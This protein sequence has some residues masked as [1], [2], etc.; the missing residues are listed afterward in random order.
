MFEVAHR[1]VTVPSWIDIENKATF[2]I[3]DE[4]TFLAKYCWVIFVSGFAYSVLSK[5]WEAI[6][7]IFKDFEPRAV[8]GMKSVELDKFPIKNQRK[9]NSFLEG[10]KAIE[11]E[12]F[13]NFKARLKNSENSIDMLEELE[14][15][16]PITKFHLA[17]SIGLADTAKPDIWLRRCAK[18]CSTNVE[19]LVSFLSDEYNMTKYEVDGILWDYCRTNQ[20]IPNPLPSSI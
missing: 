16:G 3:L 9:I 13:G 11:R 19:N 4:A 15:I 1:E 14:G 5:H 6:S 17:K 2:E 12:G 20:K 18:E 8:Y 7:K 10:S